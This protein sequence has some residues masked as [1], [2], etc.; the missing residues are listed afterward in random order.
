MSLKKGLDYMTELYTE[1]RIECNYLKAANEKLKKEKKNLLSLII[2]QNPHM[3]IS[4]YTKLEN[5]YIV[6]ISDFRHKG[7]CTYDMD[8]ISYNITSS[9]L[10]FNPESKANIEIIDN[11]L[12]IVRLDAAKFRMGHG[13]VMLEQIEKYAQANGITKIWGYIDVYTPI[14]VDNLIRFY[15]KHGYEIVKKNTMCHFIKHFA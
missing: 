15:K 4:V 5:D 2:E 14:G 7:I 12:K 1:K 11:V 6:Y 13:G 8:F 3:I 10:N 9:N